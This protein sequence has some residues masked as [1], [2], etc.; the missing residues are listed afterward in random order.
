VDGRETT[1]HPFPN[2]DQKARMAQREPDF[3]GLVPSDFNAFDFRFAA[4]LIRDGYENP[5]FA[6]P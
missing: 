1:G 2:G 4:G 5:E 3:A 6:C